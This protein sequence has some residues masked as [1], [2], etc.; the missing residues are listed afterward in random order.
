[1]KKLKK[2]IM[3]KKNKGSVL[4]KKERSLTPNQYSNLSDSEKI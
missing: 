1:M 3:T 4:V 2:S